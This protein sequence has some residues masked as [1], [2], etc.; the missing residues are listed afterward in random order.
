MCYKG[1]PPP[2]V[3][4]LLLGGRRESGVT[5]SIFR[6]F[7]CCINKVHSWPPTHLPSIFVV[8]THTNTH[9]QRKT[10]DE[11]NRSV[12]ITIKPTMASNLRPPLPESRSIAIV[13]SLSLSLPR[14]FVHI[15]TDWRCMMRLWLS[16][17]ISDIHFPLLTRK[18]YY[19]QERRRERD[20]NAIHYLIFLLAWARWSSWICRSRLQVTFCVYTGAPRWWMFTWNIVYY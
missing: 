19:T 7:S 4:L 15:L 20:G 6:H 5:Y 10:E 1:P 9:T 8:D 11:M 17:F 13:V 18:K 2:Q 14:S 3:L 16:L 12:L